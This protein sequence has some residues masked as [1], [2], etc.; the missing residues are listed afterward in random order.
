MKETNKQ[1]KSNQNNLSQ[2]M[3]NTETVELK[4]HGEVDRLAVDRRLYL[5]PPQPLD[6]SIPVF[7]KIIT[8]TNLIL[9]S[10]S[11]VS[12]FIVLGLVQTQEV[13]PEDAVQLLTVKLDVFVSLLINGYG[14]KFQ[15][16]HNLLKIYIRNGSYLSYLLSNEPIFFFQILDM[17]AN[18]FFSEDDETSE[19]GLKLF[20]EI[21]SNFRSTAAYPNLYSWLCIPNG[22]EYPIIYRLIQ[23]FST[24]N[25]LSNSVT[26]L[27]SIWS[28]PFVADILLD[29]IPPF[30]PEIEPY[31]LLTYGIL[32]AVQP[33]IFTNED[34]SQIYDLIQR[35]TS[36]DKQLIVKRI[37]SNRCLQYH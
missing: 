19:L 10:T 9:N 29:V 25:S 37:I 15:K 4:K 30:L 16:I 36:K 14:G 32:S 28:V 13:I 3:N 33:G 8:N 12:H 5:N 7:Q 31:L 24:K 27:L 21:I 34:L 20:Y 22:T 35:F 1:Q 18:T 26:D 23:L 11:S 2:N 17:F 6:I